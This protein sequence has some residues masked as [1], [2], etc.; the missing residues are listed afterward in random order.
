MKT[1]LT[2]YNR[3]HRV[4]NLHTS[5]YQDKSKKRHLFI[6]TSLAWWLSYMIHSWWFESQDGPNFFFPISFSLF[7]LC[8]FAF[9][10]YI[11]IIADILKMIL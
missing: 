11:F 3:V 5:A 2:V 4:T 7:F 8:I 1:E 6:I 10:Y 9:K